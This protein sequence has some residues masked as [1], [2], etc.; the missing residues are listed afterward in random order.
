VLRDAV[1]PIQWMGL[2]I[3]CCCG[4]ALKRMGMLGESVRKMKGDCEGGDS[5]NDWW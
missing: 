3:I 4:V 5:D 1:Y 2:M